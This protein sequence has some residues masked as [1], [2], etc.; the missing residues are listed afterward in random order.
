M[1][2]P[3]NEKKGLEIAKKDDPQELVEHQLGSQ[4]SYDISCLV[5][6]CHNQSEITLD[7]L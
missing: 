6:Y 5:T 7:R 4:T 2:K 1:G 3:A